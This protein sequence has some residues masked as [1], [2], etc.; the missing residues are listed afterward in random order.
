MESCF[1]SEEHNVEK[2]MNKFA[3]KFVT[4]LKQ[5]YNNTNKFR[6]DLNKWLAIRGILKLNKH[7]DTDLT[8]VFCSRKM[9][10]LYESFIKEVP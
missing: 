10:V 3:D 8:D 1:V 4:H 7:I 6:E 9:E 5:N 2:A